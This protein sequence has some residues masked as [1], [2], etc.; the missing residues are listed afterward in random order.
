MRWLRFRFLR[1]WRQQRRQGERWMS[2]HP[3][4]ARSLTAMGCLRSDTKALAR[5]VC[6]GLFIGF[7]P[8]VGAQI[9]MMVPSCILFRA[10][11]LAAFVCSFV[12]NPVTMGPMY[13]GFNQ[14]GKLLFEPFFPALGDLAGLS[15]AITRESIITFL[16]SLPIAV[17]AAVIGYFVA[18]RA[19][20]N[21][22]KIR[23]LRARAIQGTVL[24]ALSGQR[25]S[26]LHATSDA[27]EATQRTPG[28]VK[29]PHGSGS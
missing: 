12:T 6:I 10:N 26:I 15:G 8:T 7:T 19:L 20:R 24:R 5:G 2:R 14:I 4:L 18:I 9:M 17:P 21:R 16:G 3:R 11:F 22:E 28:P 1:T 27:A 29:P 25:K 23:Q 13:L